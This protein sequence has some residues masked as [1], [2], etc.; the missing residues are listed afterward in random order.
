MSKIRSPELKRGKREQSEGSKSVKDK[1]IKQKTRGTKQ[2]KRIAH[3][4]NVS[5][6][7]GKGNFY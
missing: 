3:L 5:E 7:E 2:W 4:Q 6:S 1:N